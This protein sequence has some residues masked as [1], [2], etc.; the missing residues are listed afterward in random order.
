VPIRYLQDEDAE[1]QADVALSVAATFARPAPRRGT[2]RMGALHL[3]VL[4]IEN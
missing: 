4:K 3:H 2:L 1:N